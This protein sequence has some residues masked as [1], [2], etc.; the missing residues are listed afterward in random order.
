MNKLRRQIRCE[1]VLKKSR[2]FFLND[3][4]LVKVK[5]DG[6]GENQI[7]QNYFYVVYICIVPKLELEMNDEF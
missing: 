3:C 4:Y 1:G 7:A 6:E 5:V 2:Y